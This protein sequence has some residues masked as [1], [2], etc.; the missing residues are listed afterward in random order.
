MLQDRRHGAT[1]LLQSI[2]QLSH[3][4]E[5]AAVVDVLGDLPHR[6]VVVSEDAAAVDA[7][8]LYCF[9]VIAVVGNTTQRRQARGDEAGATASGTMVN[10]ISTT[11]LPCSLAS[12][13]QAH[14]LARPR[15]A[16]QDHGGGAGGR[17]GEPYNHV[18]EIRSHAVRW[19]GR[20]VG[21]V[22]V[23]EMSIFVLRCDD[24][25]GFQ[26]P[27]RR[28]PI[29]IP[30]RDL[31]CPH[32][33]LRQHEAGRVPGGGAAEE[34]Q[35]AF[36]GLVGQ[37]AL[38]TWYVHIHHAQIL[39]AICPNLFRKNSANIPASPHCPAFLARKSLNTPCSC[40]FPI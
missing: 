13:F 2:G 6:A 38:I 22:L 1:A 11:N 32:A 7:P 15:Q 10:V 29:R 30:L 37:P 40:T 19:Y 16:G 21:N 14:P 36:A 33:L 25:R 26:F 31:D 17:V 8:R 35:A 23:S 9:T 4:A 12:Q 34:A 3:Q 24:P 28:Q 27:L 20:K 18:S 39:G 5:V